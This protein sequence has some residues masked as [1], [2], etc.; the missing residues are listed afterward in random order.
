MTTS[1]IVTAHCA[2]DR[3]VRITKWTTQEGGAEDTDTVIQ[4]GE[5]NEQVVYDDL[6]ITVREELK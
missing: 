2:S 5:T 1:V 3:Q 4:D 6:Q